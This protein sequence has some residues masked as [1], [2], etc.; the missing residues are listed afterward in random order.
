MVNHSLKKKRGEVRY[1]LLH[2]G[3]C[4]RSEGFHY[5]ITPTA[6]E[7][8]LTESLRGQHPQTISI[9]VEGDFET[10]APTN[11]QLLRL[12]NLILDLKMRYPAAIVGGHRQVQRDRKTSCPGRKFPIREILDWSNRE[13]LKLRDERITRDLEAQYTF[14]D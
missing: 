12:K 6:T 11:N 10:Q 4:P 13:L 3:E 5:R 8:L 2:H 14:K 1:F 9:Q 7:N